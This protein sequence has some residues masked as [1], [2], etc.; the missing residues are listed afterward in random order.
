MAL[1]ERGFWPVIEDRNTGYPSV[2]GWGI[3]RWTTG[4]IVDA[5]G[6]S[7]L[8]GV[9]ICLGPGRAPGGGW[10]IDIEGDGPEAESS[11][12][13]LFG[14]Q[15]PRTM[16]WKSRR[17]DH[18]LF[19]CDG[20]RLVAALKSARA[21]AGHLDALPDLEFKT[22]GFRRDGAIAQTKTTVPPTPTKD[23]VPRSWNGCFDVAELP[24]HAYAWLEQYAASLPPPSRGYSAPGEPLDP[25][26]VDDPDVRA[27]IEA[28][29]ERQLDELAVAPSGRRNPQMYDSAKRI[30]WCL[31]STGLGE[32]AVAEGA[33]ERIRDAALSVGQVE[34]QIAPTLVKAN[35]HA[36]DW[37]AERPWEPSR[38]ALR[39]AAGRLAREE[40]GLVEA[41]DD[42][43]AGGAAS[44][45]AAS[46]EPAEKKP[47]KPAKQPGSALGVGVRQGLTISDVTLSDD[48]TTLAKIHL[49]QYV[50]DDD[51][52][53]TIRRHA[54][55]WLNWRDAAWRD[56]DED[57]LRGEI[58]RSVQAEF[59]RQNAFIHDDP[60]H[61]KKISSRIVGDVLGATAALTMLPR[62]VAAPCWLDGV[63]PFP[64]DET[65]PMR[66]GLVHLPS[67]AAG[68][69]TVAAPTPNFFSSYALDYDFDPSAPE[70]VEFL[71]FLRSIW[72]DD[73]ESIDTLQEWFGYCLTVDTSQQKILALIGATGAGKGTIARIL[74]ALIG[75]ENAPGTSLSALETEFGM[76]KL[77]GKPLAVFSD[78]RV[79]PKADQAKIVERLLSISGEDSISIGRKY[80]KD[81]TGQLPTR[82]VLIANELPRLRDDADALGRRW[83]ILRFTESFKGREDKDLSKRIIAVE[84]PGV[85][86]WAI[87]GWRRLRERGRFVQPE[88]GVELVEAAAELASPIKSFI[89][90]CCV[91]GPDKSADTK[92]LYNAWRDWCEDNGRDH[93]GDAAGFGRMLRAAL[94]GIRN[95]RRRFQG[96][97]IWTYAGVGLI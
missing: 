21:R 52:V 17:G 89:A 9:A 77:I 51:D 65:L 35:E 2:R 42:A 36:A 7:G 53:I 26:L 73:Q 59:E 33:C 3:Q 11:I 79:S 90:A 80:Q 12:A 27:E 18:R 8:A 60:E 55:G 88:S 30:F 93:P 50:H 47:K 44:S 57:E 61:W 5:C 37:A 83:V 78:A 70:P 95:D 41:E 69:P 40:A 32:G 96:A 56:R 97:R 62:T 10:L 46:E 4:Q 66:N 43:L 6:P 84:L 82:L 28:Y 16:G 81:W 23:G 91:V 71:R 63:A 49:A 48:P 1:R 87:E 19:T 86:L 45:P 72:G 25:E 54:G 75:D 24:E 20:P 67:V 74:Q 94:P 31:I 68:S 38:T 22:G 76:A 29:I 39:A 64:A 85:L 14:D 58:W 92:S 15:I 13:R 34:S